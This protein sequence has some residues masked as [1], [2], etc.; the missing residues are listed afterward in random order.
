[1]GKHVEEQE[2]MLLRNHNPKCLWGIFHHL[3]HYRWNTVKKRLPYKKGTTASKPAAGDV[4]GDPDNKATAAS[5]VAAEMQE[6]ADP[7]TENTPAVEAKHADSGSTSKSMK[8]RIKALLFTDEGSKRRGRGRHRRSSSCPATEQTPPIAAPAPDP[9]LIALH[10]TSLASLLDPPLP[11]ICEEGQIAPPKHTC[12]VCA[13][14][15]KMNSQTDIHAP[16]EPPKPQSLQESKLFLKALDLLNVRKEVLLKILQDS[17]QASRLPPKSLDKS[18]T[19]PAPGA[20]RKGR[21]PKCVA[22]EKHQENNLFSIGGKKK[23]CTDPELLDN[24]AKHSSPASEQKSSRYSLWNFKNLREKLRFAVKESKKEKKRIVMDAVIDKIPRGR[25]KKDPGSSPPF[26]NNNNNNNNMQ[27]SMKR[28]RSFHESPERYNQLLETCFQRETQPRISSEQPEPEPEFRGTP[29]PEAT[30]TSSSTSKTL[31]RF[32]SMP[33]IRGYPSVRSSEDNNNSQYDT[34]DVRTATGNNLNVAESSGDGERNKV[35]MYTPTGSEY[36]SLSEPNSDYQIPGL[37]D[38]FHDVGD[39]FDG[40]VVEPTVC[41][42][43]L[44]S[45]PEMM[46]LVDTSC[47]DEKISAPEE[48][49]SVGGQA[50]EMKAEPCS[51]AV[52]VEKEES[53]LTGLNILMDLHVD[54]KNKEQFDYVKDVL[55][56]S[57]FSGIELLENWQ[58]AQLPLNPSLFDE[59]EGCLLAQPDCTGNEAGGT[60]DHLL[61][62]DLINHVL[63]EMYERSFSY[64]PH[65]LTC[66]SRIRRMP[67]GYR[68]LEE[69]WA[70]INWLLSWFHEHQLSVI[71]DAVSHDLSRGNNWMNLQFDAE[72]AGLELEELIL[73]DLLDELVYD[74]LLF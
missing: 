73:D 40:N 1:M 15:L 55:E 46:N 44:D 34:S 74:D 23:M 29:T 48:G 67:V 62:F 65:P 8:S 6:K 33:D 18:M 39:T 13:A 57:G 64:W 60:C 19:F 53:P 7:K 66:Y 10:T 63:L 25:T 59:V 4:G 56:L 5:P 42:I 20:L 58:A 2:S 9:S 49:D 12:A 27:Q 43:T 24:V 36:H 69:V 52:E 30:T 31:E 26:N 70:S 71:D 38:G 17:R 28:A 14:M 32:M 45:V 3:N 51:V 61:L 22:H 54:N 21:D 72:C 68:V 35:V 47:T 50:S 16:I 37:Q 41:S 11:T